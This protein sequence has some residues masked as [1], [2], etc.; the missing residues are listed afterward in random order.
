[1]YW[2]EIIWYQIIAS[3]P[4]PRPAFRCLQYALPYCKR[5]EAGCGTG[6]EANQIRF[7]KSFSFQ[8]GCT[9]KQL[10]QK[11]V[12]PGSTCRNPMVPVEALWYSQEPC[13][14]HRSPLVP[15]G[16]LWL[17]EPSGPHGSPVVPAGALWYLQEPRG[18]HGSPVV[19]AGA[20]WSPCIGAL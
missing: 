12:E 17:Q 16:A 6:N 4:V 3:F 18:P 20:P 9:A 15:A 1:M 13:D 8:V 19:P 14:S 10:V 2:R 11:G 7:V 5:R